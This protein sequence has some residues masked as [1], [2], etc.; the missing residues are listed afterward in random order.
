[1]QS[2]SEQRELKDPAKDTQYCEPQID[3]MRAQKD[4]VTCYYYNQTTGTRVLPKMVDASILPAPLLSWLMFQN[5]LV[6]F[7]SLCAVA[8]LSCSC[9]QVAIKP[10]ISSLPFS[11]ALELQ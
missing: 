7:C 10:Q 2:T 9:Y 1:M 6:S 11:L 5:N 3:A 4:Q 8:F